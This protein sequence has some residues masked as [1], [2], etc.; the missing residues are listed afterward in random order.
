MATDSDFDWVAISNPLAPALV[1]DVIVCYP[2]TGSYDSRWG[3]CGSWP[4]KASWTAPN[5]WPTI[6]MNGSAA[7]PSD[8]RGTLIVT[9]DLTFGG[10]DT[11]DGI[12][13][14]GSRIVD[15]GV[16]TITGAVVSGLNAL[17]GGW[18]SQSSKSS[19][20]R[21]YQYDS[22]M[23]Q[24]AVQGHSRLAPIPNAWVDNWIAW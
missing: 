10:G 22:C 12:V 5:Y 17:T 3:P 1:P 7:L 24:N 11:W 18:V 2:G 14:A 16:G 19:G 9:G 23:V 13:L 21:N 15:Q 20:P 8:G 4:T 6:V